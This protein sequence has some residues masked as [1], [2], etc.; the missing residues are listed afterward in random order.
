MEPVVIDQTQ[1]NG[2]DALWTEGPYP[3]HLSNGDTDIRRL[4]AGHVLIWE[5]NGLTY[6]LES[7]LKMDEAVKVAE[8]LHP[9]QR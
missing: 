5:Q 3:L 9:L 6:R 2:L 7:D 8:S 4:V 1:V